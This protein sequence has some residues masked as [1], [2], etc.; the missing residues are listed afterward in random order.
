MLKEKTCFDI[1][2]LTIELETEVLMAITE[3]FLPFQ[4]KREKADVVFKYSVCEKLREIFG[5]TLYSRI[6]YDVVRGADG[7]IFRVHKD[8]RDDGR[9]YA[10]SYM[11]AERAEVCI[12][13]LKGSEEHFDNTN[14][15]FFHAGWEQFFI[16]KGRIILHASLVKTEFG[17]LIFSGVSGIGKSTQAK[18]WETLETAT[19]INGDRPI[20]YKNAEKWMGCGSPYAGSSECYVNEQVPVRMILLLRQGME[21]R[22]ARLP[23]AKAFKEIFQ[24]CT[25]YS[26]NREYVENVANLVAELICDVPVYSLTCRPDRSAVEIVK[27]ELKKEYVL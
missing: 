4:K 3:N 2:G 9:I 8:P 20:L 15:S 16:Q 25:V 24:N 11:E 1:A 23:M 22:I 19:Q 21:C 18:L 27:E 6:E 10:V 14:N 7:Q 5:T 17:G 13:L 26:W 12:N